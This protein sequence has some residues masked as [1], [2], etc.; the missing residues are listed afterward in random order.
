MDRTRQGST[1]LFAF[2]RDGNI[3]FIIKWNQAQ[4]TGFEFLQKK[5]LEWTFPLFCQWWPQ[6]TYRHSGRRNLTS[7][8]QASW[9][10]CPWVRKRQPVAAPAVQYDSASVVKQTVC[11]ASGKHLFQTFHQSPAL[12]LSPYVMELLQTES[13]DSVIW[14]TPEIV[15]ELSVA[16]DNLPSDFVLVY[17][18]D[19]TRLVH[20]QFV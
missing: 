12:H 15:T 7:C 4:S 16:N 20:Q 14:E 6:Y 18:N 9:C 1:H 10:G 5:I 3:F 17:P 2:D 8:R 11:L 13:R 19:S